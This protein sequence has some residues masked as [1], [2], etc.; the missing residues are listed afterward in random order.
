VP[1]RQQR[2]E[3]PVAVHVDDRWLPGARRGEQLAP[4]LQLASR[5]AVARDDRTDGQADR[6]A[7]AV[8]VDVG[9]VH[10]RGWKHLLGALGAELA[11]WRVTH[12]VCAAGV[13]GAI[14]RRG[15]IVA[16]TARAAGPRALPAPVVVRV[17]VLPGIED[18]VTA[19]LVDR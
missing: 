3:P 17:A 8:A 11:A 14:A 9:H 6:I 4:N 13:L 18:A 12:A 7:A 10:P 1:R 2:I 15:N 19:A 16:R 5:I